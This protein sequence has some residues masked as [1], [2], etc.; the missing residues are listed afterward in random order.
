[1]NE[2]RRSTPGG[3][4]NK[5]HERKAKITGYANRTRPE[6]VIERRSKQTHDRRVDT[7]HDSLRDRA[8]SERFPKGQRAQENQHAWKKNGDEAEWGSCQSDLVH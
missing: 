6:R 7:P 5:A 2:Q 1:M 4:E 8:L 3:E